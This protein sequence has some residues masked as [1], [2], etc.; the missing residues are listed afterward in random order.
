[1]VRA[2]QGGS[3]VEEFIK[4]GCIAIGWDERLGDLNNM[5]NKEALFK[6][7]N[8]YYGTARKGQRQNIVSQIASFRFTMKPGDSVVTYDRDAREYHLGEIKGEYAFKPTVILQH[9]HFRGVSWHSK[10]RRDDLS[11][12]TRNTL[13]AIQTIFTLSGDAWKEITGLAGGGDSPVQGKD[14][15]ERDEIEEMGQDIQAKAHEFVKDLLRSLTWQDMQE[16]MAGILRAMGYKARVSPP[17][18]D[19]G[20]DIVASRDGLGLERPRIRAEVKH[21]PR[22]KMGAPEIRS[23]AATLHPDDRGL[24]LSTGGFTTEALYEAERAA[25]PL[26]LIDLDDLAVLLSEHYDQVGP[27]IKATVP[28]AKIYWPSPR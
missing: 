21:R 13:G 9:P 15:E 19:R 10:V 7:V 2:G 26:T 8:E 4:K 12:S 18:G 11:V 27:E 22:D 28:L 24:Y 20:K 6:A 14:V 23:F 1:M 16:V 17:G 3:L 25:T 5:T